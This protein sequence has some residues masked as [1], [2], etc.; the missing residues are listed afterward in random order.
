[1]TK[2]DTSLLNRRECLQLLGMGLL[3]GTS[4][5]LTDS[6][7]KESPGSTPEEPH[8]SDTGIA[9]TAD[10][11]TADTALPDCSESSMQVLLQD[12]P[13]LTMVGGSTTISFPNDFVHVLI[14]CVAPQ[15]WIAVW[16]ICTHGNCDV[17]WADELALVR[18]PC[19]DSLV[20]WDG[21]VI[22]GPASRSLTSFKVCLN[23]TGDGLN[24]HRIEE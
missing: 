6:S 24:I 9:D 5:C 13:E 19:H 12:H 20:D 22:Q 4:G 15:D 7:P 18:C 3:V 10:T 17:E 1:M 11:D 8:E 16:K 23:D 21:T 14:V 2:L